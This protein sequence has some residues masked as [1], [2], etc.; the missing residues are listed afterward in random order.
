MQCQG[1]H[2]LISRIARQFGA[3]LSHRATK[4]GTTNL[5]EQSWDELGHA[6]T[7]KA[8]DVPNFDFQEAT[9]GAALGAPLP[10]H[11]A[12]PTDGLSPSASRLQNFPLRA[13]RMLFVATEKE[14]N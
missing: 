4:I 7:S 3:L 12:L 2:D 13:E 9:L 14:K 10:R 1:I 11:K 6:R 8:Q 5:P